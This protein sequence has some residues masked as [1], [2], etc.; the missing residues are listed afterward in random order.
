MEDIS[1]LW[2]IR[3]HN[4]V[5]KS[6]GHDVAKWRGLAQGSTENAAGQL[7]VPPNPCYGPSML[8]TIF[9]HSPTNLQQT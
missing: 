3:M 9:Q 1:S 4:Q 8:T 2:E 7:P 5:A 6:K